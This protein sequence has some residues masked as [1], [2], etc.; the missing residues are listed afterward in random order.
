[1]ARGGRFYLL[2]YLLRRYGAAMA[3]FIERRMA[4]VLGGLVAILGL[5]WLAL[6]VM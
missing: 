4:L 5:V 6:K 3:G 2:A 1:M